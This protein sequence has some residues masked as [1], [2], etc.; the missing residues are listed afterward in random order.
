MKAITNPL[1]RDFVDV[2]RE[3]LVNIFAEMNALLRASLDRSIYYGKEYLM[4]E[5]ADVS[6]NDIKRVGECGSGHPE[7]CDAEVLK[8]LCNETPG[9]VGFNMNGYLKNNMDNK[10][11]YGKN[12]EKY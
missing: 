4:K 11:R 6:G 12:E 5:N 2:G 1:R 8:Q 7:P 10:I 3:M 9:C